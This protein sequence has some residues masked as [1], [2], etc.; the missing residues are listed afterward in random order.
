MSKKTKFFSIPA[1][2]IQKHLL[3]GVFCTFM[4]Q[5][6]YAFDS[7]AQLVGKVNIHIPSGTNTLESLF[8]KIQNQSD[9]N[10][11]FNPQEIRSKRK[12]S[13][14]KFTNV[15]QLLDYIKNDLDLAYDIVGKNIY[16]KQQPA[17]IK[18]EGTVVDEQGKPIHGAN[19]R[20]LGTN[21]QT[22]TQAN[23]SFV[24]TAALINEIEILISYIGFDSYRKTLKID[25]NKS[26]TLPIQLQ[27]TGNMLQEITVSYG[28]QKKTRSQGPSN[29]L[30]QIDS[31]ICL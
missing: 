1:Y 22:Q 8:E 5:L 15:Q 17:P 31:R 7:Q 24:L 14:Q 4:L 30:K 18:I 13:N 25:H 27:S 16:L 11:L 9:Y 6:T 28:K 26:Y 23:G 2:F 29:K 3:T 12:V 10:F 21:H 20:I 19:I